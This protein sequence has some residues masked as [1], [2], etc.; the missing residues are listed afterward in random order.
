MTKRDKAALRNQFA[1]AVAPVVATVL[2]RTLSEARYAW[3]K[4]AAYQ[5]AA[6]AVWRLADRFMAARDDD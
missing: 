6:R 1:L 4:E 5:E 2:D 3:E